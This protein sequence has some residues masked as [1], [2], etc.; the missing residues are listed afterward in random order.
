MSGVKE[1][2][3]EVL[4]RRG[5]LTPEIVVEEAT[6][7]ESPL[8]GF[9]EWDDSVAGHQYRL[10]QGRTLIRMQ[11]IVI[12]N[13]SGGRLKVRAFVSVRSPSEP[14]AG[15]MPVRAVA[16]DPVLSDRALS[17]AR[18]ELLAVKRRYDYLD[19]FV[20][21]VREELGL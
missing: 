17:N 13:P 3:G 14:D 8:H 7:E 19:G 12:V 15:Y 4:A 10:E 9:F 6:P 16:E 2:L 11:R 18:A 20:A 5:K 1:L 21:M